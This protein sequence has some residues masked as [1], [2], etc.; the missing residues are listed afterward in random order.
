MKRV[1]MIFLLT[2]V[3]LFSEVKTELTSYKVITGADG[4]TERVGAEQGSPGDVLEYVFYIKNDDPEA[5]YN[6]NPVIPI[7][8]GTTL[9]QQSI[10]PQKN[11]KV[12]LNGRDFM[13]YPIKKNNVAV[14]LGEYR[15]VSWEIPQ[16]NKGMEINLKLQVKINSPE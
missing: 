3:S 1:I 5:I 13:D 7:P 4:K 10:E 2:V 8:D 14:P 6:L 12:S 16:L 9:L 15:A 11:Y